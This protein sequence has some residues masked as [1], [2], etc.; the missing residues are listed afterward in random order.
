MT[1]EME[2]P[3]DEVRDSVRD[4]DER[5]R[6]MPPQDI[7]R[8]A[9]EHFG[10]EA[11]FASSLG[12]EDQVLTDMIAQVA[13]GLPVF[14]LDTGRLFPESYDLIECTERRY[15]LRMHLYSPDVGELEQLV[16]EEGVNLFR[17]S[18]ALRKRCCEV[19]KLRP[20]RRALSGGAAWLC[21][22]RR[23]QSVTRGGLSAVA[24]DGANDLVKVCPL[25][26]WSLAD[27]WGYVREHDVPYSPLHDKGFPSIGCACCTRAVAP[28]EDVRAGRWWWEQPEQRECGLHIHQDEDGRVRVGRACAPAGAASRDGNGSE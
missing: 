23:E 9:W 25:H 5:L 7:L 6:G 19:R 27:V 13:P 20:L 21:G 14:T 16:A 3:T 24:W 8:W 18:V 28:G 26:D 12:L 15:G 22:L 17:R 1:G 4:W 10:E 2:H 11:V